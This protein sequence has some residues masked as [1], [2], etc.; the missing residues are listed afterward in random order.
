MSLITI[1]ETTPQPPIQWGSDSTPTLRGWYS[2]DFIGGDGDTL[3]VSGNGQTQ[4]GF[5]YDIECSLNGNGEVVIPVFTIQST[6]DGNLPT[7]LFIGQLFDNGAPREIIFGFQNTGQGW[8]IPTQLGQNVALSDLWRYNQATVLFYPPNTYPTYNQ[9]VDFV[10]NYVADSGGSGVS[11]YSGFSGAQSISGYSGYSGISG[12]SGFTGYSGYSGFSAA[13][14]FS[15]Y[16]GVATSG[17]SGFTGSSGFSGFSG[18]PGSAVAS[19]YSGFTGTSGFSGFSGANPGASGFSGFTGRSGYSGFSGGTSGFSGFSGSG[20]SGFSGAGTSGFSGF[21]GK[22]GYSGFSSFSG[23]S[24]ISG[25][26]GAGGGGAGT[27]TVVASGNL[28]NTALV[29]GGGNQLAQTASITSTLSSGGNMILAGTLTTGNGGGTG[30]VALSPG[31]FA[32]LPASPTKGMI[33][34]ITNSTVNTFGAT[35]A[36]G[37]VNNVLAWYNGSAWTVIGV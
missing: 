4:T 17:F 28:T 37:G 26:S 22:S 27:V 34:A 11:G 15:G 36:G 24:G 25:Y 18:A 33:A 7:A 16:S 13:S 1:S 31:T 5:Y 3:V 10:V 6:T 29:T 23:F 32:S 12:Y 21:S 8:S 2:Q 20:F 9:M 35:V 14:G 30:V 19:G